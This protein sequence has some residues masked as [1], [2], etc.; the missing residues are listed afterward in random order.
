MTYL[1]VNGI[2]T[3][4]PVKTTSGS[5]YCTENFHED[6][7]NDS[8]EQVCTVLSYLPGI[9]LRSAG[10]PIYLMEDLGGFAGR[11]DKLLQTFEQ[12]DIQPSETI[13]E[14]TGTPKL[15]PLIEKYCD[16]DIKELAEN[17]IKAFEN[18][19]LPVITSFQKG[20]IHGDF[21]DCNFIVLQTL[22][23]VDKY[24]ISGL[25]DYGDAC[26]SFYVYEI[27]TLM[28]DMMA[29][30]QGKQNPF[31]VGKLIL[32]GYRKEFELNSVELDNLRLIIC[33][34]MIQYYV[35]G[36]EILEKD[37]SNEYAGLDRDEYISLCKYLWDIDDER[38][39]LEL[40]ENLN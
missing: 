31:E 22:T 19:I 21:N 30:C 9:T 6:T 20:Y 34:R 15:K 2:T 1:D 13:W 17:I 12:E 11:V 16:N 26:V 25:I 14:L 27:A 7:N 36:A 8:E 29:V 28:A 40:V 10:N 39:R 38:F 23:K 4:T 37:P 35:L 5:T 3:C 18:K 32:R 33:I 24:T